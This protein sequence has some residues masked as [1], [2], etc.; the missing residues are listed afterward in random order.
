MVRTRNYMPKKQKRLLAVGGAVAIV[1]VGGG[2]VWAANL[3]AD[4]EPAPTVAATA[5]PSAPTFAPT[6]DTTP[7]PAAPSVTPTKPAA[8]V[9][10]SKPESVARAWAEAYFTR[11]TGDD[12]T[13]QEAIKPYVDPSLSEY[14][15][16]DEFN[17]DGKGYWD[18]SEGTRVLD[19]KVTPQDGSVGRD[20][21]IRW[22]RTVTVSV[23]GISTG[24]KVDVPYILELRRA[25]TFWFIIGAP[26][27]IRM[28]D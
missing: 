12:T 6:A 23:E 5:A 4:P 2:L 9:D 24:K 22:A 10:T 1:L 18:Q 16:T 27:A 19:V 14:M 26:K 25:D 11:P 7:I 28:G 17:V 21:P 15:R 3:P 13:F 20:T 8:P